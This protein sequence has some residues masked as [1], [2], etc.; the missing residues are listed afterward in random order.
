MIA[1]INGLIL[2]LVAYGAVYI[3]P[4]GMVRVIGYKRL[5]IV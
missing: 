5:G 1:L 3:A 4:Y 2:K